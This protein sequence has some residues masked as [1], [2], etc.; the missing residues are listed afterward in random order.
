[1]IKE[2]KFI[3]ELK[4]EYS[5]KLRKARQKEKE[6]KN[7]LEKLFGFEIIQ[8]FYSNDSFKETFLET[9]EKY[10]LE[11]LKNAI[12]KVE[13]FYSFDKIANS[14]SQKQKINQKKEKQ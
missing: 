1:M 12:I 10:N 5:E 14:K 4:L 2:S 9:I 6:Q 7:K 3:E 13:N 8:A 11:K